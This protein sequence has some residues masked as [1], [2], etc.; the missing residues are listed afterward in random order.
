MGGQFLSPSTSNRPYH[1]DDVVPI[2]RVITFL[3]SNRSGIVSDVLSLFLSDL[4]SH[5]NG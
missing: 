5:N 4:N 2:Q 3:R 1:D